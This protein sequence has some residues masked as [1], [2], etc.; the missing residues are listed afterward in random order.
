MVITKE[1]SHP[2]I[3]PLTA[4][5]PFSEKST[6]HTVMRLS[7]VLWDLHEII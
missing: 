6:L 4:H 7:L 3:F 1:N 5:I 2:D